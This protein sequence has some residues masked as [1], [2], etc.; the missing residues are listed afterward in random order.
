MKRYCLFIGIAFSLLVVS[1]NKDDRPEYKGMAR[2][3]YEEIDES[4]SNPERGLYTGT[5]FESEDGSPVTESALK[6]SLKFGRTLYM[7]ECWLIP[8]FDSDI[9]AAYLDLIRTSLQA[10]RNV[11][12]KCILRFGY[13]NH[14]KDLSHPENDAPFD[15]SEE[16]MLRHIAQIK[17]I[18]QEY[19]DVIY[20]LQAGFI[21]CWGEWHYTTGFLSSP[22]TQEEYLPRRR[23][24][25]ALLDA[26][27]SDRQV[28][29]RTPGAKMTMYGYTLADTITR[30][31]AHTPISK[32]R[33]A[34][35]NDCFLANSSD[36][37]TFRTPSEREYW[38][39]ES[40]YTIMGGETCAMSLQCKCDNTLEVM[41]AQH[42]SYLN[43]SFDPDVIKYWTKNNCFA[44]IEARLGYRLVL[45][46]AHF[47]R[48]AT[49]GAPFRV[50]LDI[51]N[52]G[53]AP[54]MNPRDA[55]LVLTDEAG[56]V[57]ETWELQSDPRYWMPGTTTKIDQSVDL[58]SGLSGKYVLSLNLPDPA[59]N[60]RNNPLFS[61]RLANKNIW[62][63]ETGYNN[64]YTLNL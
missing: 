22:E 5:S 47:T 58:P 48:D 1:C 19:S 64:L 25:E 49:D 13:S 61:V 59:P 11:G 56:T 17:P 29:L 10:Y 8:F 63:A 28:E 51:Y 39:A 9:S 23:V 62:D 33:L 3:N 54:I 42:F 36:Q 18:L 44:D 43:K 50:I 57:V 20:V 27:P 32:A 15:T 2:V 35:H 26:L 4:F 40:R 21:G 55:E 7:L 31:E 24:V 12:M 60:L 6:A 30:A 52:K 53:F 34:G 16:Q 41:A 38:N 46:K 37:G 45:K 14:I